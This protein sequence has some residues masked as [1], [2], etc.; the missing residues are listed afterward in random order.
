MGLESRNM[1]SLIAHTLLN[2]ESMCNSIAHML[3]VIKK[4]ENE[5]AVR[6]IIYRVD[7][8]FMCDKTL[9]NTWKN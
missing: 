7:T 5:E 8:Y 3:A 4:K 6:H 9:W 1:D 2:L